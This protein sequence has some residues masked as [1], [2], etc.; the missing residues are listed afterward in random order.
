MKEAATCGRVNICH[1]KASRSRSIAQM[2]L[3]HVHHPPSTISVADS[4]TASECDRRM[5]LQYERTKYDLK[6]KLFV[7]P[8][9]K[10]EI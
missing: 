10:T 2:Q 6:K 4:E 7:R 1:I 8:L 3:L 9:R 5:G